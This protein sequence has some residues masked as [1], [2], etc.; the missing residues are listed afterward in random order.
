MLKVNNKHQFVNFDVNKHIMAELETSVEDIGLKTQIHLTKCA[1][2]L[3]GKIRNLF[4]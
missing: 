2:L 3:K 4:S 1:E